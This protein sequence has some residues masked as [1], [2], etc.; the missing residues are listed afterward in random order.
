MKKR[1]EIGD[2]Y[3][4]EVKNGKKYMQYIGDD[5]SQLYSPVLRVFKNTYP[6][7]TVY[8]S[9]LLKTNETEF[10]VHVTDLALGEKDGKWKKI[11]NCNELGEL[12]E[13]IFKSSVDWFANR[14]LEIS[15]NWY[16]WPMN[17]QNRDV[18]VDDE[19][20]N[21]AFIG[22][23]IQPDNVLEMIENKGVYPG[24]YPKHK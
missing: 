13:I 9:E 7:D 3:E 23:V 24:V 18:K 1:L 10:Y 20:L 12:E 19:V 8:S 15:E 4:V 17:G 22:L 2:V 11:G 6:H 5:S 14:N 16:V 21:R